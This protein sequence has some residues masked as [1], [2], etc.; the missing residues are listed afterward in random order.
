MGYGQLPHF[1]KLGVNVITNRKDQK[2]NIS[3][4]EILILVFASFR[5]T[6]L[7]VFDKITEMIRAPFFD[8][9][10]EIN[11]N[12][13]IEHF[14]LPKKKGIK[15][16]I[17][18]LLGCYWCTGIWAAAGVV[19]MYY[20]FPL[21]GGLIVLILAIAGLAAIIEVVVQYYIE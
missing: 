19:V 17:G 9:V 8:E 12:G 4:L 10:E 16:F 1:L 11:A 18:E 20:A 13:E 14:Y 2:M 7:I 5:L 15:K 3:Y 21:I 6:R